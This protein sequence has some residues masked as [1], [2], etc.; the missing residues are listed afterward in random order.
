MTT[1][2]E[3]K[4][5]LSVLQVGQSGILVTNR[6]L[7]QIHIPE[8]RDFDYKARVEWLLQQLSGYSVVES[9][10]TDGWV[11]SRKVG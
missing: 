10:T 6:E 3:I 2:Q 9:A 8:I 11:F 1:L 4:Q 7:E 5:R